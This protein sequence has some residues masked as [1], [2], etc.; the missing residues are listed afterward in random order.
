M[1]KHFHRR[2]VGSQQLFVATLKAIKNFFVVAD[3]AIHQLVPLCE[4]RLDSLDDVLFDSVV[5]GYADQMWRV[6]PIRSPEK[7]QSYL[8]VDQTFK[9]GSLRPKPRRSHSDR[10]VEKA[11]SRRIFS[12]ISPLK[13]LHQGAE[14]THSITAYLSLEQRL[15]SQSSQYERSA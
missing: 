2:R 11:K 3:R 5:Q 7:V 9:L 15:H 4:L 14:H 13:Q 1:R 8:L 6:C 12:K 10:S